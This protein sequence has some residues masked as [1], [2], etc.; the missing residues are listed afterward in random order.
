MRYDRIEIF[1]EVK[2]MN[3][4]EERPVL[5]VYHEKEKIMPASDINKKKCGKKNVIVLPTTHENV[6]VTKDHRKKLQVHTTYHH[7]KSGS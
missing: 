1:K 4:R 6:K 2:V 3:Y 7:T 5:H